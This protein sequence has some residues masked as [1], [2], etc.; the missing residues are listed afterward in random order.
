MKEFEKNVSLHQSV[1]NK[2]L[3][4]G[5]CLRHF[6]NKQHLVDI[7]NTLRDALAQWKQ[8]IYDSEMYGRRLVVA[9]RND[10]R[11]RVAFIHSFIYFCKISR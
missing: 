5:T 7:N 4:T 9:C 10:K 2:L 3:E 1:V 8:L 11:V 6:G